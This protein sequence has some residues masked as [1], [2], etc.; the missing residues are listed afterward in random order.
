MRPECKNDDD[1]LQYC[2]ELF[3]ACGLVPEYFLRAIPVSEELIT[4]LIH[5]ADT[6][7]DMLSKHRELMDIKLA[8]LTAEY[9]NTP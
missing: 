2:L 7:A 5:F 6:K 3:D 1:R 8:E 9:I 4:L